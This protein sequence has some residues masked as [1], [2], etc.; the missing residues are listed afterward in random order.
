MRRTTRPRTNRFPRAASIAPVQ[1]VT[2]SG[3]GGALAILI[4]WVLSE[5]VGMEITPE[6]ASAIVTILAFIAGYV[7][8]PGRG[9][10]VSILV[11]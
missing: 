1:K 10:V 7:T 4:V 3:L 9:E 8:P 11:G 5:F 2:A 6:V